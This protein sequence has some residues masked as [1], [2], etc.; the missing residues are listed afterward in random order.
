[1]PRIISPEPLLSVLCRVKTNAV[2]IADNPN[3]DCS[4]LPTALGT[5]T[6]VARFQYAINGRS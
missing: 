5:R 1:M 2:G 6:T 3:L 4:T